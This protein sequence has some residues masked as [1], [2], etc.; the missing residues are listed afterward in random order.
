MFPA[1]IT[2]AYYFLLTIIQL[3]V[4]NGPACDTS[5]PP[6]GGSF[7]ATGVPPYGEL[8]L[9]NGRLVILIGFQLE[10]HR[11]DAIIATGNMY[12]IMPEYFSAAGK[13]SC[14]EADCLPGHGTEPL[15]AF[16]AEW[17]AGQENISLF[18]HFTEAKIGYRDILCGKVGIKFPFQYGDLTFLQKITL[19]KNQLLRGHDVFKEH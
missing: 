15:R 17:A 9:K 1:Y 5:E 18:H 7:C 3:L 13:S 19:L 14:L 12:Q 10:Y 4:A 6:L 2:T 11:A 8:G 16:V